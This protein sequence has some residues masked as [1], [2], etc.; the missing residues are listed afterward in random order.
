VFARR[1][2]FAAVLVIALGLTSG[3]QGEAALIGDSTATAS[4][5]ARKSAGDIAFDAD[6]WDGKR[7]GSVD[8]EVFAL[9]LGAARCAVTTGAVSGPSTLTVIDYSRASTQPR[10]WVYDLAGRALLYEELVAH[11]QG[12][13]GNYASRFSNTPD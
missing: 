13:G 5:A 8:P 2:G 11:G 12:S 3:E 6:G 4:V 10:L 1:I 7:L 9:A